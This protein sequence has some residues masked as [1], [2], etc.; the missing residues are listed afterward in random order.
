MNLRKTFVTA[1]AFIYTLAAAWGAAAQLD[2]SAAVSGSKITVSGTCDPNENVALLVEK[3]G[4]APVLAINALADG[5]GRFS[6]PAAAMPDYNDET[7]A[8][9]GGIYDITAA[10]ESGEILR[11]SIV[12][13][14]SAEVG[15]FIK[16]LD[17]A[18]SEAAFSAEFKR[19]D[20]ADILNSVG[21]CGA[22]Y[23]A[24]EKKTQDET[25]AA[26]YGERP[27]QTAE[28]FSVKFDGAFLC[29]A[30]KNAGSDEAVKN[31]LTGHGKT[32]VIE[33][34]GKSFAE[35][36]NAMLAVARYIKKTDFKN[37]DDLNREI[38]RGYIL[39]L[40]NSGGKTEISEYAAKYGADLGIDGESGFN[41]FK[42]DYDFSIGVSA[43]IVLA[44]PENGFA[45]I[46]DFAAVFSEKLAAAIKSGNSGGGSSG[47]SSSGGGKSAGSGGGSFSTA[48]TSP[49]GVFN[50]LADVRW[51]E[52]SI[53]EL[54]K[55]GV[56]SESPD[57]LFRPNS[58]VTRE[59]FV[60]MLI[61]AFYAVD[62]NAVCSF[63]D[64]P[65]GSW[66]YPYAATAEKRKIVLGTGGNAFGTGSPITRQDAAVMLYR[67]CGY[68]NV[69]G[70]AEFADSE[71]IAPYAR[72]AVENLALRGVISG[73]EDGSFAPC[74]N[75]TRA[76]AAKLIYMLTK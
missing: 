61:C 62:A 3:R 65:S 36:N 49:I 9:A 14:S 29:A 71:K 37:A 15:S 54:C 16:A 4:G 74:E 75:I 21:A 26:L 47:G 8:D 18:E 7:V 27:F 23:S 57:R 44:R 76:Q 33:I 1:A 59:E 19:E 30:I 69:S 55:S 60:K 48:P 6:S 53:L 5:E 34:D 41:R 10:A 24:A 42:T 2:F 51:A 28:K 32:A 56:I 73:F 50:D 17:G 38:R 58:N 46:S 72:E 70:K 52:E 66:Y 13:I 43:E 63:A 45:A 64:V 22:E 40:I 68:V 67:A 25:A 35:D 12:Y 39:H 31:L 20:I 11:K